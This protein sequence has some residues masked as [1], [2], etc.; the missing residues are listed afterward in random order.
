MSAQADSHRR[1]TD[2]FEDP[3]GRFAGRA[4]W[5]A[6][7]LLRSRCRLR[8]R[9]SCDSLKHSDKRRSCGGPLR[10]R[11]SDRRLRLRGLGQR[12][13]PGREGLPR[14]ACSSAA[15]ASRTT[16]SPRRPGSCARYFWM[17]KLGLRGDPAADAVQGRLHRLRLRRRRRQPRL[18]EHALPRPRRPSSATAS[19]AELGTGS[20]EL[21]PHYDTAERMLGV[22]DYDRGPRRRAAARVRRGDRRRRDLQADPRRRLL[23]RAGR[24]GRGPL[25]RRRGPGA[26]RL[27][28]AA[29]AAWSAAATAPRTRCVKNYLWFAEKLGVEIIA[30]RQV[31][32]VRPLGA[33]TTAPTATR[34][35]ASTR[36]PGCASAGAR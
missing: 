4:T 8:A 2:S 14:R 28:R 1:R 30:E 35:R 5:L 21:A 33:P 29:A 3:I 7:Q 27:H 10:L 17:P 13:A 36:A 34:S 22:A 23:R 6:G 15:A 12:A 24:D 9:G 20:A 16:T 25:L 32:D 19:G 18:R 26:A 31:T 11:L